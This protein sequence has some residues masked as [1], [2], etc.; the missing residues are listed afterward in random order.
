MD[1]INKFNKLYYT[2]SNTVSQI[3]SVL[4]G[5][6]VTKDYEVCELIASGGPG[7]FIGLN[8]YNCEINILWF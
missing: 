4:P 7:K 2:V 5:N 8:S 6:A 3:A 1:V